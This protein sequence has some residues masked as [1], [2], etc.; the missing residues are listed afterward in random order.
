[1]VHWY[2]HCCPLNSIDTFRFR[3]DEIPSL[4]QK[5]NLDIQNLRA[6]FEQTD[7]QIR[8]EIFKSTKTALGLHLCR[9]NKEMLWQEV[10]I[11]SLGNSSKG[12][13]QK[14]KFFLVKS[15]RKSAG[16]F[17]PPFFVLDKTLLGIRLYSVQLDLEVLS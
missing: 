14:K 11:F 7:L 8:S 3:F 6:E 15:S 10:F 9:L 4:F 17:E 5:T 12:F 13:V 1:M 16:L 2:W